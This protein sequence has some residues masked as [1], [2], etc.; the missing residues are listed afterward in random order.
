MPY[1]ATAFVT[2]TV[3]TKLTPSA[4]STQTEI[5]GPK[6]G[7]AASNR[8][9]PSAGLSKQSGSNEYCNRRHASTGCEPKAVEA[10]EA[11]ETMAASTDRPSAAIVTS[12][13]GRDDGP[14]GLLKTTSG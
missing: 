8:Q 13:R 2:S 14:R 3:S 5:W 11:R 6:S 10:L 12:R 4:L 7:W 1:S 9:V